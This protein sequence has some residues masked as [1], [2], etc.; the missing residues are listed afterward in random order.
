MA[1]EII[2]GLK[3]FLI[4]IASKYI[5][6]INNFKAEFLAGKISCNFVTQS[7]YIIV[8]PCCIIIS[9]TCLYSCY[10]YLLHNQQRQVCIIIYT[11]FKWLPEDPHWEVC[12]CRIRKHGAKIF[13]AAIVIKFT[14]LLYGSRTLYMYGKLKAKLCHTF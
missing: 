14:L 11:V 8:T 1:K 2:N 3:S 7:G 13:P 4:L 5:N 6:Q 10:I 9:N 12:S